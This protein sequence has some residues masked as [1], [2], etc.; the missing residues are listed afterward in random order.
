[1]TKGDEFAAQL[2]ALYQG[3]VYDERPIPLK[4]QN[5]T[6]ELDKI[7]REIA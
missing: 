5:N 4:Y 6:L 7:R 3:V 2:S 1:M